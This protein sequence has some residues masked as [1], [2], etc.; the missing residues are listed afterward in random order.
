M[1]L[2]IKKNKVYISIEEVV[3]YITGLRIDMVNE[4]ENQKKEISTMMWRIDEN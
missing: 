1:T 3:N 4:W 2:L